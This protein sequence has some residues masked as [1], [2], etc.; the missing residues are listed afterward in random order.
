MYSRMLPLAL[1]LITSLVGAIP[2]REHGKSLA[3]SDRDT[4]GY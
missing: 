3:G 1:L 2:L 4:V